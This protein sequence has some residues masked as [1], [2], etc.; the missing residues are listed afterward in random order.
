M[1]SGQGFGPPTTVLLTSLNIQINLVVLSNLATN[2]QTNTGPENP[3]SG[4]HFHG[5][6]C[7]SALSF[8]EDIYASQYDRCIELLLY[9]NS[10]FES[11]HLAN[12]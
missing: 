9:H 2:T 11:E 6:H 12:T 4:I 10:S 5:Q 8:L 3:A 7:L 1:Q